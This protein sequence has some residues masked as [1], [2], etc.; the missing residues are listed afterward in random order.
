[1]KVL[2]KILNR[3]TGALIFEAEVDG[4]TE[5]IRMGLTVQLA[6]KSG[7]N[8]SGANLSRANLSRATLSG[9]NL[10]GASLSRANLS[11]ATLFE[12]NLCGANLYGADLSRADLYGANLSRANLSR[13][14]LYGADLSRA[15][16]IIKYLTTPLY[17]LL[18]QPGLIRAYKL[19]TAENTGP[20]FPGIYYTIGK[21]YEVENSCCDENMQCAKGISLASLDWCMKEWRDGCKILVAEFTAP[22]IAAIPIG[23][24]G[25]FR[26]HRCEI[27]GEKDLVELGLMEEKETDITAG[28]IFTQQITVAGVRGEFLVYEY[29]VTEV[30]G[31]ECVCAVRLWREVSDADPDIEFLGESERTVDC[32][33]LRSLK[34]TE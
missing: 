26:V 31:N 10:S 16:G 11:E 1:M 9:A 22:D 20:H 2:T 25:K 12:A 24:D 14:N 21:K 6:Y 13:A 8:L 7:V 28:D 33:Y 19:V 3:F 32:N 17:I 34:R 4:E 29:K 18:D 15:E 30:K 27:V 23:S 5:S